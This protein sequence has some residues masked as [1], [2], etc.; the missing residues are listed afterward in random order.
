MKRLMAGLLAMSAAAC[1][2]QPQGLPAAFGEPN[3]FRRR[4]KATA[5]AVRALRLGLGLVLI[6][7][8]VPAAEIGVDRAAI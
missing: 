8:G 3:K 1:V 6:F 2:A 7:K 5:A 4:H